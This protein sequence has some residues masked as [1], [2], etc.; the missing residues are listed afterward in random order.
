ML[1]INL[2]F[3]F[4]ISSIINKFDFLVLA[5]ADLYKHHVNRI[6]TMTVERLTYLA[7]IFERSIAVKKSVMEHH[8]NEIVT[9]ADICIFALGQ[10]GKLLIC[11]NG[12]S[13]ADAQHLAAELL[14]RID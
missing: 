9:M 12:G 7:G 8:L 5:P 14:V 2:S 1:Y 3:L 11:G 10:G 6:A 4:Y 13:A